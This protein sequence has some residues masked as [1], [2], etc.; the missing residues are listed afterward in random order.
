MSFKIISFNSKKVIGKVFSEPT[1]FY[2]LTTI[3]KKHGG[4]YDNKTNTGWH[5]P[6]SRFSYLLEELED[7]TRID[8][9]PEQQEGISNYANQ[10]GSGIVKYRE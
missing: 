1:N 4:V 5:I 3:I 8:I 10:V 6:I 7:L 9:D 2:M